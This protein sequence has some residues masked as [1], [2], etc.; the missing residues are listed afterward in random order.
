MGY[1]PEQEKCILCLKGPVD[2]SAGAGSG[3]TFTLTQRIAY[4]LSDPAS[5]VDDIGQVLAITFTKK[6]AAE[7]KSRVRSTLRAQG[8]F[9][10]ARKVDGA[11]I[12]TIHGM[13]SRILHA[14]A[15]EIG[16]DPEFMVMEDSSAVLDQAIEEVLE[17][18]RE[19]GYWEYRSLFEMYSGSGG[20][21][22]ASLLKTLLDEAHA[23]PRGFDDIHFIVP[24]DDLGQ[25]LH[26][27]L[28]IYEDSLALMEQIN[29]SATQKANKHICEQ[30]IETLYDLMGIGE[31]YA[32]PEGGAR[33]CDAVDACSLP[34]GNMREEHENLQDGRID[35][36]RLREALTRLPYLNGKCG[37]TEQREHIK[38]LRAQHSEAILRILMHQGAKVFDQL[39][40]LA[41]R[42]DERFAAKKR[43]L[44]VLDHEDLVRQTLHALE[45]PQI[46][47]LYEHTFHLVMVDEFQDTDALQLAIVSKLSGAGRRYLCTVGDAQQS[48]YRFRG[49]DVA[50]YRSY[51]K[52]MFEE[53][54]VQ[55]G[56]EPCA[57]RLTRNF[58][59]HGDI[60]A[61]VKKVCS[62]QRVFGQDFL[63]L[64]AV[65]DG[66]GYR[67]RGK[68]PRIFIDVTL[69]H[70]GKNETVGSA[71]DALM[72][73][74]RR[75]AEF[76]AR[77]RAA[78]HELSQMVLLLGT[79]THA[80]SY[81]QALRQAGF[82]CVISGGSLFSK[83]IEAKHMVHLCRAVVNFKDNEA[84]ANTLMGPLFQLSA[85]ELLELASA[86]DDETE[87]QVTCSLDQGMVRCWASLP[88]SCQE[89]KIQSEAE[90][91]KQR[92]V[93]PQSTMSNCAEPPRE[94]DAE[95]QRIV[96]S[97]A[98]RH[99]VNVLFCARRQ[100]RTHPLSQ[101]MRQLLWQS[102]LFARLEREGAQGSAC[103]GNYMKALRLIE[104]F[105]KEGGVGP[106]QAS[107]RYGQ[108]I[109][110]GLN[111][112]PGALNVHDQ[113]A[114]RIMTIHAAKGLEFPIVA[115]ADFAKKPHSSNLLLARFQG[116]TYGALFPKGEKI[117]TKTYGKTM[118]ME[119]VAEEEE[120]SASA[121][122]SGDAFEAQVLLQ[123]HALEDE[124]AEGQRLFYVGAT[125]AKEALGLFF[126]S[127]ENDDP[128][129]MYSGVY[130]DVVH[131]LF[132]DGRVPL[133]ESE[134]D[135]GGSEPALI[136]CRWY[137]HADAALGIS[138]EQGGDVAAAED[139]DG[140]LSEID[141]ED[142]RIEPGV[143]SKSDD[144]Q[145]ASPRVLF[146]FPRHMPLRVVLSE[147]PGRQHVF[148]Y[149]SLEGNA[150]SPAEIE[151]LWDAVEEREES[152]IAAMR[153]LASD[154]DKATDF[155]SALHRLCQLVFVASEQ[156]ARTRVQSVAQAYR[157]ADTQRLAHA[158]ERWLESNAYRR[159]QA[160]AL[161]FPEYP[162]AV[163]F[164]AGEQTLEGVFDLLCLD[165]SAQQGSAT[166]QGMA[167]QQPAAWQA[168][169]M[170]QEEHG[171]SF[172]EK[173]RGHAYVVDYKTGGRA[174]ETAQELHEKHGLQAICY[175]YA[176]MK[177]GFSEIDMDFVRVE[178][179][180][181]LGD[182]ALQTVS[183][184][185]KRSDFLH[186]QEV[187][188]SRLQ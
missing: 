166:M 92:I 53:H 7:L 20:D 106:A 13:C 121:L 39:I 35:A 135:C 179:E 64:Q 170:Q 4:A 186:L 153:R 107:A 66:S 139:I 73:Q 19:S 31:A 145:N 80:E 62:Q 142:S 45:N 14:N 100:L 140:A 101:V 26:Q 36:E 177:E 181:A 174:D 164:G 175:A 138:S 24:H 23:L 147:S 90:A 33:P 29:Q 154:D 155:G 28:S 176:L 149:T 48:I 3:K 157:I 76:F 127:Q 77:M 178:H 86:W 38:E 88:R 69:R 17:E 110:A 49:A 11:W 93:F 120:I 116:E 65:Y 78:G 30:A 70:K 85:D 1:T 68:H 109:D 188:A 162:F 128:E 52:N 37:T 16:I 32:C 156:E 46:K 5:G 144:I 169:A 75:I 108:A 41:R 54:T 60:L 67:A 151:G 63:D 59:S 105:E 15:L 152:Q 22:V 173:D 61:F 129:K 130:G 111:E 168:S 187:I 161:Q 125:R 148:S 160:A 104:T 97:A 141:A 94:T 50:L 98:V 58:R 117:G 12:S 180:D 118:Q 158:L 137:E 55:A 56:G 131:A 185:F 182:D 163:R 126:T 84:L 123:R 82:D 150:V 2:V 34:V 134:V 74:A 57:L 96:F 183:F 21:S 47:A 159:A 71:D 40:C 89:T 87:T 8:M 99:A 146:A 122:K 51:Q 95:K 114:I 43:D 167:S 44:S 132:A 79:T 119:L 115:M 103:I 102:G 91:E 42:V 18:S 27:L 9:E 136:R 81:A 124:A 172:R 133:G 165:D 83:S 143:C 184:H 171:E 113:Q 72:M 25:L 6:A 10:Q 112:A